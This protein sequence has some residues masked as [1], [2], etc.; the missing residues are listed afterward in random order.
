MAFEP[1]LNIFKSLVML[2]V[3]AVFL[4]TSIQEL[5]TGGRLVELDAM[6]LYI[7][8]CLV[9]YAAVLW[10]LRRYGKRVQSSILALEIKNW[11]I[12]A[13]LTV[14]IMVSLM[15]A[16]LVIELGHVGYLALY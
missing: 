1:F 6:V 9:V 11:T 8:L 10:R 5:M 7:A 15:I 14:G 2:T 3:L 12:D 13:M 4:V 16:L